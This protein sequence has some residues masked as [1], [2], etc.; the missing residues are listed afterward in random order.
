[1]TWIGFPG[2]AKVIVST[3]KD[4]PFELRWMAEEG[5]DLKIRTNHLSVHDLERI[6]GR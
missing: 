5:V 4:Y 3:R 1:M 2:R 6:A